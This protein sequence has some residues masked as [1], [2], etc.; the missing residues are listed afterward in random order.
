VAP[1]EYHH[2]Q[3][4]IEYIQVPQKHAQVEYQVQAAP[5]KQVEYHAVPQ[6]VASIDYFSQKQQPI[7]VQPQQ[8]YQHESVQFSYPS[9]L[10]SY[11]GQKGFSDFGF[12]YPNYETVQQMPVGHFDADFGKLNQAVVSLPGYKVGQSYFKSPFSHESYSIGSGYDFPQAYSPQQHQAYVSHSAPSAPAPQQYG[13]VQSPAA[14]YVPQ[15]VSIA[16]KPTKTPD[17]ASGVKGLG[18]F[19][20]ISAIPVSAPA[21]T[22]AAFKPQAYEVQGYKAPAYESYSYKPQA[23]ETVVYKSQPQAYETHYKQQ[24]YEAPVNHVYNQYQ[25]ERPFKASAYLGSSHVDSHSEQSIANHKPAAEY[26]PPSKTYL[27]A[28]EPAKSYLPAKEPVKTYLPAK[29]PVKNYLP[30][31]EPAK[32][33][34]PA[35]MPM[36]ESYA[37]DHTVEYQ[38]QY[39]QVPQK[40]YLPA[41]EASYS[42]PKASAEPPKTSYLP[43]SAPTAPKKSYLPPSQPHN[44]YLPPSNPYHTGSSSHPQSYQH[45]QSEGSYESQEYQSVS[46]GHK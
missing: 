29:E 7:Q 10:E 43:P 22:Q 35:A 14:L 21:P 33:Y 4:K 19:S 31:R 45:F 23:Y 5:Q 11:E 25:T 46:S 1:I 27:P 20:T 26:L 18:H 30:A 38:I 3:T 13:F 40:T 39:V 32:T 36:K 28:K 15:T 6:K 44:N 12:N 24:L 9:V 42:P 37:P 8:H 16:P 41:A 34:L 2:K 17:Y